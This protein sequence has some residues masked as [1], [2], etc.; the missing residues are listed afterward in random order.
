VIGGAG[1]GPSGGR[2]ELSRRGL[3]PFRVSGLRAWVGY[4]GCS[5]SRLKEGPSGIRQVSA[6][7]GN[8]QLCHGGRRRPF[9][10]GVREAFT[11]GEWKTAVRSRALQGL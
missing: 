1:G 6:L 8:E 7:A 4:S 11:W 9:V 10:G 3:S 5:V 2:P